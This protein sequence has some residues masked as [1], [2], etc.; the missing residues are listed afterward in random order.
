[1]EREILMGIWLGGGVEKKM[2][3]GLG[4]FSPGPQKHFLSKMGRKLGGEAH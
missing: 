1:M 4:V 2:W 3:W